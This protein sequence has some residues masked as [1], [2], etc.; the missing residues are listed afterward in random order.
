MR[1]L[2]LGILIML[3]APAQAEIATWGIESWECRPENFGVQLG[4]GGDVEI[5]SIQ[6]AALG[7]QLPGADID[8]PNVRQSLVIVLAAAS[9]NRPAPG[10]VTVKPEGE[11]VNQSLDAHLL[12]VNLKQSGRNSVHLPI[13]YKFDPP[14]IIPDGKL[15]A[16]IITETYA[17]N[18]AR[19]LTGNPYECLNTEL[20]LTIEFNS[21]ATDPIRSDNPQ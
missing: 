5:R 4:A 11:R 14:V 20:H 21:R 10:T 6:G 8:G 19:L 2:G 7:S 12:E 15:S 18:P 17:A 3:S 9:L 16:V 13:F 1:G